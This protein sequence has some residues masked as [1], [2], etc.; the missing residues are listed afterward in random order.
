MKHLYFI[1]I[2]PLLYLSASSQ[3]T[4]QISHYSANKGLPENNVLCF[5]PDKKAIM[6]FGTT[7]AGPNKLD[8]YSF[9]N[10]KG[11]H[12]K[13]ALHNPGVDQIKAYKQGF[14]WIKTNDAPIYRF[15]LC[16]KAFL[17]IPQHIPPYKNYKINLNSI[18]ILF[19]G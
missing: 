18:N 6:R 9:R 7:Y 2:M 14:L 1:V 8:G 13:Y 11:W 16:A 15:D 4:T 19:D 12:Q 5:L 17:S 10:F 3:T